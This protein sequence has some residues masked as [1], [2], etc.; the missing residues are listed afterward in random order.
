MSVV[1]VLKMRLA[2]IHEPLC[3]GRSEG[4]FFETGAK[5]AASDSARRH[6]EASREQNTPT[7]SIQHQVRIFGGYLPPATPDLGVRR[8]IGCFQSNFR[9]CLGQNHTMEQ[10]VEAFRAQAIRPL[11][12]ALQA[13]NPQLGRLSTELSG[14]SGADLRR[15]FRC[16]KFPVHTFRPPA[17]RSKRQW[18][19]PVPRAAC[20]GHLHLLRSCTAAGF[21]DW[22]LLPTPS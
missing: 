17:R 15:D 4:R 1:Q 9:S 8:G 7:I 10:L 14:A 20:L 11:A 2:P 6:P 13:I 19:V 5:L 18:L 22:A 12:A 16:S 3:E 21:A